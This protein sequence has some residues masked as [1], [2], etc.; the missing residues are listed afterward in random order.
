MPTFVN[1]TLPKTEMSKL[2]CFPSQKKGIK[3]NFYMDGL[4][5]SVKTVE[6][7]KFIY[8]ELIRSL[9][10]RGLKTGWVSSSPVRNKESLPKHRSQETYKWFEIKIVKLSIHGLNWNV[11]DDSLEVSRVPKKKFS[12]SITER[13]VLLH[14]LSV[15]D[16][17]GLYAPFTMQFRI[18]SKSIW[19]KNGQRWDKE[20]DGNAGEQFTI[21]VKE[22][23]EIDNF[24]ISRPY[25]KSNST[26][27]L[28]Y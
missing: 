5:Y 19:Q 9:A 21:W 3:R 16:R 22:L 12:S 8:R 17:L 28:S 7:S 10:N 13:A 14:A 18:L 20:L 1:Y 6:E 27:L 23:Q 4:L 15:F 11:E 24:S 25:F 2:N 26:A